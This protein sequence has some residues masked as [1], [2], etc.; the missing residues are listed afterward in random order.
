MTR[1]AVPAVLC[2]ILVFASGVLHAQPGLKLTSIDIPPTIDGD[3]S[4]ECWASATKITDFYHRQSGV[5]AL[6]KTTAWMTYD[7]ESIYVAWDCRDSEPK[8]IRAQQTKRGG[9]MW[10]DDHVCF[11]IDPFSEFRWAALNHFRVNLLGTQTHNVQS[12]ETGK[13]EWTGDWESGVKRQADGYTVEMRIPFSILKYDWRKPNISVAFVRK[14]ARLAQ[15]FWAPNT[16]KNGDLINIFHLEDFRPPANRPKPVT[17]IY[18]LL[19]TGSANEDSGVGI[20][21]KHSLT[22]SL[23]GLLTVNPDFRNVEQQ[24]DSV[25]FTYTERVLDDTR[26]FFREGTQYFPGSRVAYSRRIGE[27]DAGAKLVGLVGKTKVAFMNARRFDSESYTIGQVGRQFGPNGDYYAWVGGAQSDVETGSYLTTFTTVGGQL[28]RSKTSSVNIQYDYLN[29]A[30]SIDSKQGARE[31]LYAQSNSGPRKLEFYLARVEVDQ[32][33]APY[34]GI[35]QDTDLKAWETWFWVWDTPETGSIER[36][37][38]GFGY[39]TA[40]HLDGSRFYD[41]ISPYIDFSWRNGRSA[42]LSYTGNHRLSNRDSFLTLTYG[43]GRKDIYRPGGIQ[44]SFG[45]LVGGDYTYLSLT[46]G[47]RLSDSLSAQA[48]LEYSKIGEPSAEAGTARQ[49]VFS[50]NYDINPERGIVARLIRREG[51]TNLYFAYRQKVRA[52]L[53]AYLIYGDP[54]AEKTTDTILLKLIRPL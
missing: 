22:P 37:D 54:N 15:E 12:S 35:E 30:S 21:L 40:D 33:Y 42:G 1:K 10:E 4:D 8:L 29:S 7:D 50:A 2:L 41:Y 39:E 53:D 45:R 9:E 17:M 51:S 52:G 20:D 25:D 43:W 32:D 48:W 34:L 14:H 28:R 24:V 36:W 11:I 38:A 6:E 23:S 13:A 19:G 16:G 5:S 31:R 49:M 47:V 44:Y 18:A 3:L 26:P 27:I 46:Q